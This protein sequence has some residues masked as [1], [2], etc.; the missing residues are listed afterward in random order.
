MRWSP[1]LAVGAVVGA[2]LAAAALNDLPTAWFDY[3]TA[4]S[5][6]SFLALHIGLAVAIGL[7]MTLFVDMTLAAA[8]ALTREAFPDHLDWWRLWSYRA[9]R[10]VAGRALGG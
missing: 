7:T 10:D 4:T 6:A 2:L 1:A 3:D 8:E 5:P 9:T